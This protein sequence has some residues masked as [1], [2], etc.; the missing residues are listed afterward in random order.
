[1]FRSPV[2][3]RILVARDPA[4]SWLAGSPA[5]EPTELIEVWGR[6]RPATT[7]TPVQVEVQ[8]G[9]SAT[10]R[11]AATVLTD[12]NGIFDAAVA[13]AAGAPAQVRFGWSEQ[14]VAQTSPATTPI[15]FPL[16]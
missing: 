6:I 11:T 13:I 4:A 14:G 7:P 15:S 1:M 9:G 12:Q 2:V 3:A 5:G 8:D 16:D 10:F